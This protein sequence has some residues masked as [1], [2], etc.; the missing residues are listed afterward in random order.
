MR[1][2]LAAQKELEL[3]MKVFVNVLHSE[4]VSDPQ[5]SL[6][7]AGTQLQDLLGR[8]SEYCSSSEEGSEEGGD[9]PEDELDDEHWRSGGSGQQGE[10]GGQRQGQGGQLQHRLTT[11]E[12][13]RESQ[14]GRLGPQWVQHG[15]CRFSTQ[16]L[17]TQ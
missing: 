16:Q 1:R 14:A 5:L 7:P 6:F 8:D 12:E 15:I 13:E 3:Q 4:S 9:S 10:G 2:E 11:V 17:P